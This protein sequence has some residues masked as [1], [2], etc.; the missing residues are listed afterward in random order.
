MPRDA[1][2]QAKKE[3]PFTLWKWQQPLRL[4][5][6]HGNR[7]DRV[8]LILSEEVMAEK[9]QID[10]FERL[11]KAFLKPSCTIEMHPQ[12][13]DMEDYNGIE[14]A[15]YDAV[16]EAESFARGRG[17]ERSMCIDISGGQKVWSAVA[18]LATINTDTLFSYV[19]TDPPYDPLF[20]DGA[21]RS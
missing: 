1:D 8:V 5:R 19:Q 4:L 16:A 7:L 2:E 9:E 3:A 20:Y 13:I 11:A 14:R 10:S 18:V 6:H 21:L 15:I 12:A 17:G